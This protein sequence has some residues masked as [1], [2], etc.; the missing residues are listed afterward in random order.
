MTAADLKWKRGLFIVD[1]NIDVSNDELFGANRKDK[2]GTERWIT[3]TLQ[4][5]TIVCYYTQ[6]RSSGYH[7]DLIM[8]ITLG[9]ISPLVHVFR[10]VA[11]HS[12]RTSVSGR[13][14][15]PVLRL[16]CS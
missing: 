15:F 6:A 4:T 11:W 8:S 10:L 5:E 2:V 9:R 7:C 3:L 12:G 13:R 1:A 14:T 16:T